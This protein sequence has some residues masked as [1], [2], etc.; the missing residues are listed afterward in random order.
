M[1][2]YES[3]F[4]TGSKSKS[5]LDENKEEEDK[6]QCINYNHKLF[7]PAENALFTHWFNKTEKKIS[8]FKNMFP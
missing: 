8:Y 4:I 3:N 6:K 5:E 7:F 2:G 1:K